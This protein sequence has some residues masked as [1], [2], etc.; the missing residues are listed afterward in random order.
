MRAIVLKAFRLAAA[1]L[2]VVLL[3]LSAVLL[4]GCSK[5]DDGVD[6]CSS[7]QAG[8]PENTP[9]VTTYTVTFDANGGSGT[10][11]AQTVNAGDSIILPSGT[12][13][14]KS[15]YT[16]V[17]W[18]HQSGRIVGS[19]GSSYTPTGNITLYAHWGPT[20]YTIRFYSCKAD[21]ENSE[22][23]PAQTVDRGS[24]I[25][26]PNGD[27]LTKGGYIFDGW[28]QNGCFGVDLRAGWSYTPSGSYADI[29]LYAQWVVATYTVTFDANGG[30]GTVP[31]AQTVDADSSITLP[32]GDG[33]IRDEYTFNGWCMCWFNLVEGSSWESL[34]DGK[35][36]GGSSYT[37]SG[38][39]ANITL[40]AQWIGTPTPTKTTFV[41]SR[42]GRTYK[43]V[44]IGNQTW[45]AEN[46][47][48]AAEGSKCYG[49]GGYDYVSRGTL[50][51][52][53]VQANCAKYGR[54]YNWN[55]AM[56]GA[57]SS[58]TV[59]SGVQGVCP[60]GWHIP[61]D[62]EWDT[63]MTYVGGLSTAGKKLKSVTGWN[64]YND[65]TV[66]TDEF[67][68]SALPGGIGGSGGFFSVAGYSGN[69]WSA[70]E[71][72]AD[73]AWLRLMYYNLEDVIRDNFYNKSD[74]FSVRCVQDD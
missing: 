16:L 26:I 37:P 55:T 48:Y 20:T 29:A 36:T 39:D 32:S 12:G 63:L 66:G 65:A 9:S 50:T 6:D 42:D 8:C 54:L 60:V 43:K 30:S 71:I 70:T 31:P 58:S 57:S 74:L 27:E 24:S 14:T 18:V 17:G 19:P 44:T 47:S 11:P 72:N 28:S 35:G 56:N 2:A 33:L 61:S 22:M 49:E 40:C 45:M 51:D 23:L 52:S 46:L 25:T 67:G 13:L 15:G 7:T 38:G 62:S 21:A 69:W 3:A 5:D 10:I 73:Y 64:Y 53:E 68:F 1:M 41:D 59:P 34:N 4:V